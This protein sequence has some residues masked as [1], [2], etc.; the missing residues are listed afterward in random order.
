[1]TATTRDFD[2]ICNARHRHRGRPICGSAIA[3]SAIPV[4]APTLYPA[5]GEKRIDWRI[6]ATKEG[7]AEITVKALTNEESDAMKMA[8]P[9]F[10]HGIRKQFA[11]VGSI[12]P[13]QEVGRY[14]Y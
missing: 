6:L 11:N 14:E 12:A 1:M 5:G 2:S 13:D 7:L 3:E 4:R 10:I 8:F 9:V